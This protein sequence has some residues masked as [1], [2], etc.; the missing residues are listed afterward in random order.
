MGHYVGYQ[1]FSERATKSEM[2]AMRAM[3]IEREGERD[4][5]GTLMSS[6]NGFTLHNI[7]CGS[8]EEAVEKIAE[9]DNGWYDDHGVKYYDYSGVR[10]TKQ[11]LDLDKRISD[12]EKKK[13]EYIDENRVQNRKSETVRCPEC[14]SRLAIGYLN[15]QYCPLCRTDLRSETVR[16]KIQWFDRKI[17]ELNKKRSELE[18]KQKSKASVRWLVKIEFHV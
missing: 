12:M 3:L 1:D 15:T 4:T 7:V 16:N 2:F 14:G 8:Y 13:S 9:Y 10:P 5:D 17:R 11:M 18:K 6:D